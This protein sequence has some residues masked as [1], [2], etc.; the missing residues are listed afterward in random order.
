MNR[1]LACHYEAEEAR[2]RPPVALTPSVLLVFLRPVRDSPVDKNPAEHTRAARR[3][4]PG[5]AS[6]I[7]EMVAVDLWINAGQQL[8]AP[9]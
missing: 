8:S 5:L 1:K 4:V 9:H 6:Y 2:R 7:H 3:V